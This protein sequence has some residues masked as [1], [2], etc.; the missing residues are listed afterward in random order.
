MQ[1]NAIRKDKYPTLV[2]VVPGIAIGRGVQA[3]MR[4]VYTILSKGAKH[5]SLGGEYQERTNVS[6]EMLPTYLDPEKN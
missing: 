6:L 4:C 2:E 1:P 5:S 3:C